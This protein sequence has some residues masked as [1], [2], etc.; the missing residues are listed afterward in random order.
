MP[1]QTS[2][3]PRIS[4]DSLGWEVTVTEAVDLMA[5]Y[6]RRPEQVDD[7]APRTLFVAA[8]RAGE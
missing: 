7:A 1:N 6:D 8:E 3:S 2:L 4:T 5:R